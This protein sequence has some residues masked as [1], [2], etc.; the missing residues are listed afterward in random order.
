MRNE[1]INEWKKKITNIIKENTKMVIIISVFVF[2]ITGY[3][4]YGF[5]QGSDQD[6]AY[7]IVALENNDLSKSISIN[8]QIHSDYEIDLASEIP[9]IVKEIYVK[10]GDYVEKGQLLMKLNDAD[11]Q[12]QVNSAYVNQEI[13]KA[14]L[15][16]V[17]NP[18]QNL[19][20]DI[21]ISQNNK[22]IIRDDINKLE[23][24]IESNINSLGIYLD[25]VLRLDIDDY[26]EHVE[27]NSVFTYR[28]KSQIQE[29]GLESRRDELGI[30][31][32][33]YKLI[34]NKEID[35]SVK[36]TEKFEFLVSELRLA[37]ID[38]LGFSDSSSEEKEEFL[39]DLMNE[40]VDK[41]DS[42]ISY[43]NQLNQLEK[44]L[45]INITGEE[46]IENSVANE[47]ILLAEEKVRLS[48]VQT[49]NAYLDLQ[50][51][52]IK[53]TRDG[54]VINIM[55]D[56]GEYV[57][58]SSS[59]IKIISKDKYVK[60][61]VPE[62][63]I[64]K[65]STGMDVIIVLDAFSKNEFNGKIDF[66]YPSE[67]ESQGIV[68]YEIKI[69]LNSEEIE[70]I[71]I[72]P[73]MSLEVFITYKNKKD[74]LSIERMIVKEENQKYFVQVLNKNNEFVNKYFEYGFIGDKNIE[75]ISGLS[76]EDKIIKIITQS[77][78]SSKKN[79]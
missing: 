37:S 60:A 22:E 57:N 55:K 38:F 33:E 72:L 14:S 58:S 35:D 6:Q 53:A 54:I 50:K 59:L 39:S 45:D 13:N 47:D 1:N 30:L 73:G 28:I 10:E 77:G 65:I 44:Q 69:K 4:T 74:V 52:N 49:N 29:A 12:G 18:N 31:F 11:F 3:F 79:K 76:E 5:F 20:K 23:S 8:G 66:I 19:D 17:K 43:K 34:T 64:E 21:E 42:L 32:K 15:E 7:K 2:L 70:G 27:T 78:I 24:D 48:R 9:G 67:L 25:Q 40:I 71:N 16:Q 62:V 51:T 41:K 75:V 56:E 61:L 36:I 63:D 26:F 46:K 68:Y